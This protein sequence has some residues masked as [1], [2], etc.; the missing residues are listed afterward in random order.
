[1]YVCPPPLKAKCDKN[2]LEFFLILILSFQAFFKTI[3]L[4]ERLFRKATYQV[5]KNYV[6]GQ[7]V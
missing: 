7:A 1:M 2:Y 5:L 3:K 4:S 6:I